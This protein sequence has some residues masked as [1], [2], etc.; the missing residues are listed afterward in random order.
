M[1][2]ILAPNIRLLAAGRIV[3]AAGVPGFVTGTMVGCDPVIVDT[4]VGDITIT[5]GQAGL[6]ASCGVAATNLSL[7]AA[8]SLVAIAAVITPGAASTTIRFTMLREG[9]AGAASVA[10]DL[11]FSFI[12]WDVQ[13]PVLP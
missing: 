11:D 9:A 3:F 7:L 5:I 13:P 12:V 6:T 1:S 10:A 2:N 4:G 8:S